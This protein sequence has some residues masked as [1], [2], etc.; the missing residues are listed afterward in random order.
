MKEKSAN[1]AKPQ[2]KP[3][4]CIQEFAQQP[5]P[6]KANCLFLVKT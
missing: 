6:T 3:N 1:N 4:I 2:T 5:F